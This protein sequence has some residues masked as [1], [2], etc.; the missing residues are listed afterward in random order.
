M[1]RLVFIIT[2]FGFLSATSCSFVRV[3]KDRSSTMTKNYEVKDFTGIE[4][5]IACEI[6]YEQSSTPGLNICAG[7]ITMENLVVEVENGI[8]K[9]SSNDKNH[10]TKLDIKASSSTLTKIDID[11]ALDFESENGMN[12]DNFEFIINGAANIDIKALKTSDINFVI[13]GAGD[14]QLENVSCSTIDG[15][16]NGAADIEISG[17]ADK[18]L[19][20]VNGAGDIDLKDLDCPG[21]STSVNGASRKRD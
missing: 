3:P 19:I 15:T 7:S 5:D 16:V 12:P 18:A 11:G 20:Q 21:K 6:D 4:T 2:F 17:K 14:I 13:N 1:K 9:I 8:L 10:R